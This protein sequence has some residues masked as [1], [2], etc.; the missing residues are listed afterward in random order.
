MAR[1]HNTYR[2]HMPPSIRL[3]ALSCSVVRDLWSVVHSFTPEEKR[4]FLAF[5]TGSDRA[6]IRGLG[7]I[8]FE[9][10]RSG[11]SMTHC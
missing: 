6:P 7:S 2:N 10:I 3:N 9:V 5:T 8:R 1:P 4:L 11:A